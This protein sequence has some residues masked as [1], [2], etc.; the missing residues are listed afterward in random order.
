MEY[1]EAGDLSQ[2]LRKNRVIPETD[3]QILLHQLSSALKILWD[4]NLIHRDLKPQNLLL[5]QYQTQ[6][7]TFSFALKIA[8]FGFARYVEPSDL[9]ETLC[10]SPLYMVNIFILLWNNFDY[11]GT[12]NIKI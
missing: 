8:D 9:A 4:N 5:Q 2:L 10:G 1:C 3:A 11:I 6:Q 7:N 12:G